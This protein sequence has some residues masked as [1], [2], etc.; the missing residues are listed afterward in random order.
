MP[1]KPPKCWLAAASLVLGVGSD[2]SLVQ[3]LVERSSWLRQV[4]P[5]NFNVWA[6]PGTFA[7]FI[8]QPQWGMCVTMAFRS[9]LACFSVSDIIIMSSI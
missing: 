7:G 5:K 1:D 8:N 2:S 4:I 9:L 6:G 3:S